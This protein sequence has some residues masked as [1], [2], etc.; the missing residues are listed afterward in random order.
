MFSLNI[1]K[2]SDVGEWMTYIA[3]YVA[4]LVESQS[5]CIYFIENE[6][7]TDGREEEYLVAKGVFGP[8][9]AREKD[10]AAHIMMKTKYI[11]D[12]VLNDKI[13][14]GEDIVG[15]A[16]LTQRSVNIT[17]R[18][19]PRL[20]TLYS[21]NP[22]TAVMAVPLLS[23]GQTIGVVCAVDNRSD[24][25]GPFSSTQFSQLQ[26]IADQIVLAQLISRAYTDRSIQQ[27]LV[28]ELD[29]ARVIQSSLLPKDIPDWGRF[30]M[31]ASTRASKEVS[32]DFY[33]FVAIDENRLLVVVG[34]ASGKGIPACMI[35]S[36]TRSFIRANIDRFTTLHD[37]LN[38]LND[39][40]YR[41][42]GDGRYI[43]L[44][45]C[46]LDKKESTLEFA[47]AGHTDLL[48]YI[49]NHIRSIS[50]KGAGLGLLPSELAEFDTFRIEFSPDM[51]IIMYSDGINEAVSPFGEQFGIDRIR[52]HFMASCVANSSTEETVKTLMNSVDEFTER[53]NDLADDQ[54]VVVIKHL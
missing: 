6:K 24:P 13:A 19:D 36:M 15:K 52:E 45:I 47:R 5:L 23:E 17:K 49:H 2:R 25:D 31:H 50:P 44:G 28:Q 38:E 29:F 51:E 11:L 35:M 20:E 43:T 40:L 37:L 7:D 12:D 54:T 39:N 16:A 27:R 42:T 1:Q 3:R 46:L 53:P 33:D 41:D 21:I 4:D 18:G 48:I 22:V 32:G 10:G 34:D 26:F 9:P 8:F 30:R 14:I